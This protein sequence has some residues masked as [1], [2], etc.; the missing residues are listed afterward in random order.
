M[1]RYKFENGKRLKA[2][3]FDY[4]GKPTGWLDVTQSHNAQQAQGDGVSAF[5][6]YNRGSVQI[7]KPYISLV[8]YLNLI[9]N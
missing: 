1:K 3:T 6:Y 7:C 8:I 4:Y 2:I 5:Y 9:F